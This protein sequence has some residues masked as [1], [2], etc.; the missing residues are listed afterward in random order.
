MKRTGKDDIEKEEGG[1]KVREE[2]SRLSVSLVQGAR[3]GGDGT[4][5]TY[6]LARKD[7]NCRSIQYQ[8]F[9]RSSEYTFSD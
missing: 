1:C 8:S 2:K 9:L 4:V 5:W 6:F 7:V 3:R